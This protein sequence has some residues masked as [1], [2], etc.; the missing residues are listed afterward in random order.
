MSNVTVVE[1]QASFRGVMIDTRY[2]GGAAPVRRRGRPAQ[3]AYRI[4][5][6]SAAD[7]PVASSYTGGADWCL[8]QAVPGAGAANDGFVLN[9]TDAMTGGITGASGQETALA[10][11]VK[12]HGA[13]F[14]LPSDGHARIDCGETTYRVSATAQLERLPAP[15]VKLRWSEQK[16]LVGSSLS[17]LLLVL[18]T[19]LVPPDVKALSFDRYGAQLAFAPFVIAPAEV[20]APPP[21]PHG[22]K[23]AG[24]AGT[25]GQRHAG[26]TG[27][28][29]KI[30]ER[31][32]ERRYAVKRAPDARPEHLA[33]QRVDEIKNSGVLG[34]LRPGQGSLL[35][36][37]FGRDTAIGSDEENLLGNL[38]G[39]QLG[40]AYGQGGL[41]IIDSG[42]GGAGTG[43]GTI[44]LGELRT[45]ED[46]AW[47]ARAPG[48]G[49]GGAA[50][51]PGRGTMVPDFIAGQPS[52]RGALDKEIIRRIVRR[53]TNEVKYCYEQELVRNQQ[54]AGRVAVNFTIAPT[55]LV[56]AAVL[57]SSSMGNVRVEACI[58]QA[59]RRWEF[60]KP[61][62][63]G[64]VI[65]TYPFSFIA[66][67]R[68]D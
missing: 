36:S 64:I 39:S 47:R 56:A 40:E 34:L 65:A 67:G 18:V 9:V 66:A 30:P 28:M 21:D 61:A 23:S 10:D 19:A 17:L 16:Y 22:A 45:I 37:V 44:G 53:H 12:A 68:A 38:I 52:V 32:L 27:T 48:Y 25:R 14:A 26:P 49:P 59:V 6:T 1:V 63:G 4:G 3:R 46:L 29:G 57:Q 41:D 2:L 33:Q 5:C 31:N 8:V 54:L 15:A 7:A 35:A 58:V 24:A 11:W 20:K 13:S 51:L 43:Q 50:R 55:G 42:A 60:P 62:G